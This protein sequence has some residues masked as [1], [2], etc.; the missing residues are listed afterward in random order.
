M[1]IYAKIVC[2]HMSVYT[3]THTFT[4]LHIIFSVTYLEGNSHDPTLPPLGTR[5]GQVNVGNS[6]WS[7]QLPAGLQEK[8]RPCLGSVTEG[9]GRCRERPLA[10]SLRR[11]FPSP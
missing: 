9:A 11:P 4:Q 6:G 7:L 1:N 3:Y 8:A 10:P 2:K 5:S